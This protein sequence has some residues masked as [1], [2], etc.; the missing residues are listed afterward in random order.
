[1]RQESAEGPTTSMAGRPTMAD[2]ARLAVVTS[3]TVSRALAGSPLVTAET[4]EKVEDAVRAT[5]YVINHAARNLR[6]SRS[7]Q[8][9]VALPN[10]A[11]PFYSAVV[12]GVEEAARAAGYG[13]LLGNTRDQ[14]EGE[15]EI[16]RHLLTGA[17]DGLLLH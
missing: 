7:R 11:N 9:L 12:S 17:V 8:I 6:E 1:M 4:R 15:R 16:A 5:G 3:G 13:V 14:V 10:I 2:V